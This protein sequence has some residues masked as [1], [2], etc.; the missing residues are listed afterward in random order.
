M[1]PCRKISRERACTDRLPDRTAVRKPPEP[2]AVGIAR[3]PADDALT[4]GARNKTKRRVVLGTKNRKPDVRR[5][6]E[7]PWTSFSGTS[8]DAVFGPG[9]GACAY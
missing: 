6:K 2:T 3:H 1:L 4:H 9:V 5:A 7:T 8:A